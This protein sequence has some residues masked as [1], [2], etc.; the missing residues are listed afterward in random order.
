MGY[1][2][3]KPCRFLNIVAPNA[4]RILSNSSMPEKSATLRFAR[5]ARVTKHAAC[6][7]PLPDTVKKAAQT[8]WPDQTLIVAVRPVVAAT[9]N[10]NVARPALPDAFFV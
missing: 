6:F 5:R 8:E 4:K 3:T 2:E 7:R 1:P 10:F 9:E